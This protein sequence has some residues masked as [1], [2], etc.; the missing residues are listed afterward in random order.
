MR[1]ILTVLFVFS[2]FCSISQ[3]LRTYKYGQNTLIG[4]VFLKTLK[5]PS[6][7]ELIKNALVLVLPKSVTFIPSTKSDDGNKTTTRF[8][9]IYGDVQKEFNPLIKYKNIIGKKVSITA[10]YIYAPSWHYPLPVNI[11][12]DFNYKILK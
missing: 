8:I 1:K 3:N 11:I 9:R 4:K 2:S 10:N 12:E 5:N 6:N 7:D